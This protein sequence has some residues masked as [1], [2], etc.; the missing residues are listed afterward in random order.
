MLRGNGAAEAEEVLERLV[1]VGVLRLRRRVARAEVELRHALQV[2]RE[3]DRADDLA[4]RRRVAQRPEHQEVGAEADQ[5]GH[6]Q[7]DRRGRRRARPSL[8]PSVISTG[9]LSQLVGRKSTH[10]RKIS[11]LFHARSNVEHAVHGHRPLGEVDD[12][13][14]LVDDDDAGAE[15]GVE[16]AEAEAGDE[17]EEDVVH[18]DPPEDPRSAR[19]FGH[20]IRQPRR[21]RRPGP[22]GGRARIVGALV[23][24]AVRCGSACPRRGPSRSSPRRPAAAS[25]RPTW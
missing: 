1:R 23:T 17:V 10:G 16:R 20:D 18:A 3:T 13:R 2:Q 21:V 22:A 5:G 14:A 15:H 7:G 4:Q 8:S 11:P 12:A 9:M 19:T 6:R 25:C 24:G